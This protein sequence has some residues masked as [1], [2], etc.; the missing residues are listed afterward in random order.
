MHDRSHETIATP[1]REEADALFQRFCR[2]WNGA[3]PRAVTGLMRHLH[4]CGG[5]SGDQLATARP[6]LSAMT[7]L[8]ARAV[9]E[10]DKVIA[11]RIDARKAAAER[12]AESEQERREANACAAR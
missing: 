7:K 3:A 10:A 12:E 6:A 5:L 2:D 11:A 8:L 1:L 9:K 4:A